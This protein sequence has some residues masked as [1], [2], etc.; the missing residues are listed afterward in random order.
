MMIDWIQQNNQPVYL[1]AYLEA[2]RLPQ[3]VSIVSE[4]ATYSVFSTI[5]FEDYADGV[6]STKSVYH[7]IKLHPQERLYTAFQTRN[8]LFQWRRLPS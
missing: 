3:I 4:L 6:F 7:Q 2:Y 8:G 5:D 1:D